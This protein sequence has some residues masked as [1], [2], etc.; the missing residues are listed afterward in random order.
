MAKILPS[1]LKSL[2]LRFVLIAPFVLQVFGAVGLVV[3]ALISIL[4][5]ILPYPIAS[6]NQIFTQ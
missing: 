1:V 3:N 6:L 2:P 4:I 5:A